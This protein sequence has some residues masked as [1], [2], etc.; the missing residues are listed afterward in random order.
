MLRSKISSIKN[1]FSTKR[2]D[3]IEHYSK[4]QLGI[5]RLDKI[6]M[7][8]LL[9]SARTAEEYVNKT[10]KN[11]IRIA[12]II[13]GRILCPLATF[14][15]GFSAFNGQVSQKIYNNFYNLIIKMSFPSSLGFG[16]CY[17]ITRL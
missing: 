4:F 13:F 8:C 14:K 1:R 17:A 6:N 3:F 10:N 7:L 16:T 5:S 15:F 12:M 11:L 2:A 9:L